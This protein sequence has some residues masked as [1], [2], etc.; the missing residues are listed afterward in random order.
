VGKETP[1]DVSAGVAKPRSSD[2]CKI[3]EEKLDM[4]LLAIVVM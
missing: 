1:L 2:H 3:L 4:T